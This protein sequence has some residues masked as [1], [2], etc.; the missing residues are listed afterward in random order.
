MN[1]VGSK[2]YYIV[3]QMGSLFEHESSRMWSDLLPLE[4][5]PIIFGNP[6]EDLRDDHP[7]TVFHPAGQVR[8]VASGGAIR[9]YL[10]RR[11]DQNTEK[12]WSLADRI[13]RDSW[14]LEGHLCCFTL[15]D[16]RRTL[17]LPLA[18]VHCTPRMARWKHQLSCPL[19]PAVP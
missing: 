9:N 14:I 1:G 12:K 2:N 10:S 13:A 6:L 19:E 7:D 3:P 4:E 18:G 16:I 17:V 11:N 8:P 15:T 5:K